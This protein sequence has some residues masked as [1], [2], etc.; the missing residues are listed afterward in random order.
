[1]ARGQRT[2]AFFEL[3]TAEGKRLR[4]LNWSTAITRLDR[5]PAEKRLVE[6]GGRHI[7]ADVYTSGSTDALI[8]FVTRADDDPP[9]RRHNTTGKVADAP[10]SRDARW[11]ETS[12]IV[13]VGFGNMVAIMR[14]GVASPQIGTFDAYLNALPMFS[15]TDLEARPVLSPDV[16]AKVRRGHAADQLTVK[17]NSRAGELLSQSRG[18]GRFFRAANDAY[19]DVNVEVTITVPRGKGTGRDASMEALFDDATYLHSA[20]GDGSPV[21]TAK[22]RIETGTGDEVHREAVNFVKDRITAKVQV[23]VDTDNP[24]SKSPKGG[25][26]RTSSGVRAI[27]DAIDRHEDVLRR[28]IAN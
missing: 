6:A 27:M 21:K 9:E 10:P 12:L 4:D 1:M 20:V 8:L 15:R 14:K 23:D 26:V 24:A 16:A 13:P 22:A 28:A 7:G 11:V 3:V 18:L 2:V 17:A 5:L 25:S 19:G